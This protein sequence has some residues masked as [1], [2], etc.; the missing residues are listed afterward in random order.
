MG[1]ENHGDK[2]M[3]GQ[4]YTICTE[5][6]KQLV[7]KFACKFYVTSRGTRNHVCPIVSN[8]SATHDLTSVLYTPTQ[9]LNLAPY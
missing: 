6:S 8:D 1:Y 7:T 9:N 2:V 3:T 5:L 4:R